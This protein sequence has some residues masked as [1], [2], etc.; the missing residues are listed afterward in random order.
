[1][2]AKRRAPIEQLREA[3]KIARQ[4]LIDKGIHSKESMIDKI[5]KDAKAP[6][7]PGLAPYLPHE[8]TIKATQRIMGDL[9]II[10]AEKCKRNKKRMENITEFW[11]FVVKELHTMEEKFATE[12]M[13]MGEAIKKQKDVLLLKD[14]FSP[15]RKKENL[16][17]IHRFIVD[18][19]AV[20]IVLKQNHATSEYLNWFLDW[21]QDLYE[22]W[23]QPKKRKS[24]KRI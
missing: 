11:K 14:V 5:V 1:M 23:I 17:A 24:I 16:H 3:S 9:V 22:Y 21:T 4:M 15:T 7:L 2:P 13:L 12:E 20:G 10:W 19:F 18:S 8:W 6:M